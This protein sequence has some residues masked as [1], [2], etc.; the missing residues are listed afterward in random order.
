MIF[1]SEN[2][3]GFGFATDGERVVVV[4]NYHG[5]SGSYK[6]NVLPPKKL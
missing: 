3:C 5:G 6:D 2:E 4:A 1:K